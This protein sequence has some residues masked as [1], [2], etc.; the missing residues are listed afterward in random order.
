MSFS[1][2]NMHP[3]YASSTPLNYCRLPWYFCL[4]I[5]TCCTRFQ[6]SHSEVRSWWSLFSFVG[7]G[8]WICFTSPLCSVTKHREPLKRQMWNM[9]FEYCYASYF[10]SMF[11][12]MPIAL[13]TSS[14]NK[15]GRNDFVEA[16]RSPK[17]LK[18]LW[19]ATLWRSE[20]YEMIYTNH[21]FIHM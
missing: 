4:H 18:K 1:A 16:M 13:N 12:I 20:L 8:V 3:P 21:I 11:S 5:I 6:I 14:W 9:A 15:L 2:W 10:S 19:P 17:G 7:Q